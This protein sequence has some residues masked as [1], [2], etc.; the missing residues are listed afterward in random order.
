MN[1]VLWALMPLVGFA[2]GYS[3]GVLHLI[4]IRKR[5]SDAYVRAVRQH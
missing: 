2:I 3:A 4:W 1:G 5:N